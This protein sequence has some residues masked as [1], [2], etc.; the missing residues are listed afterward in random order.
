MKMRKKMILPITKVK[1]N[2]SFAKL[3]GKTEFVKT[4]F[5]SLRE[6]ARPVDILCS[7]SERVGVSVNWRQR[8]GYFSPP[9]QSGKLKSN[10][11][12]RI[13]RLNHRDT[14]PK[15]RL[16]ICRRPRIACRTGR[17]HVRTRRR[18]PSPSLTKN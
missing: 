5:M 18:S 7:L 9:K 16:C 4:Y 17:K 13:I 6:T 11:L 10:L 2:K 1:N 14:Q 15:F 3:L 12:T 8:A